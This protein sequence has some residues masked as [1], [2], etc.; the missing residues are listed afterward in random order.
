MSEE[1]NQP[2]NTRI[3]ITGVGKKFGD[4]QV[5]KDINL[6]FN[7]REIVTVVGPSG[8]GKTTLLRCIDGLIPVTEGQV[9]IDGELMSEPREGVSMVFQHFGLF[10]WKTVYQNVGYGLKLAGVPKSVIAEKVPYFINLVGLQGFEGSYPYQLSGGMQQRCGFARALAMEP[11]VLLMDEPFAAVD[12]QTREILQF[13]LLRIWGMRPMTMIFVTH[14]IEEAVLVGDR[15]VVLK[16]RP[17]SVF[18]VIDVDLPAPRSRETLAHPRF[19]ELREHVWETLM[20]EA[21]AAEFELN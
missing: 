12:A 7:E 14:S 4:L 10:P 2:S 18:E 3:E 19:T 9:M 11:K 15:V 21:R 6:S 8:C 5:F 20:D 1:T 16:G 13:E 17:S